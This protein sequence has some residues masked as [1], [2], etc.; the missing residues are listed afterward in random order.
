M[1]TTRIEIENAN[2]RWVAEVEVGGMIAR[3]RHLVCLSFDEVIG[4]VIA[5]YREVNPEALPATEAPAPKVG[6]DGKAAGPGQGDGNGGDDEGD[7]VDAVLVELEAARTKDD[8][9]K[10]AADYDI[11]IE[12]IPDKL[13]D[14]K[15]AT[16]AGIVSAAAGPGQGDGK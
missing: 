9:R 2:G 8:V 6:D 3:R 5:A 11:N 16:K 4:K 1:P 13:V 12:G 15:E 10:I 14:L 7:D